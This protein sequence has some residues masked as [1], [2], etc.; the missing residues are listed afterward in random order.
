MIELLIIAAGV[1][2]VARLERYAN[3]RRARR[4]QTHETT[5]KRRRP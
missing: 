2:A 3:S 5:V 1:V 4:A